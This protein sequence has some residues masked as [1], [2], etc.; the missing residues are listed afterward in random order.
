[1]DNTTQEPNDTTAQTT[2]GKLKY[3]DLCYNPEGDLCVQPQTLG[4]AEPS[5]STQLLPLPR[6]AASLM[7]GTISMAE[8]FWR[9]HERCLAVCLLLSPNLDRWLAGLPRQ[10]SGPQSVA[11]SLQPDDASLFPAGSHVAGS[12]QCVVDPT[13]DEVESILPQ[14]SGVHFVVG[15]GH[16]QT[17]RNLWAFVRVSGKLKPISPHD[18]TA[19]DTGITVEQ[20]QERITLV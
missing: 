6:I 1:M 5:R 11:W 7:T 12:W 4:E 14:F 13:D 17:P 3:I 10:Q 20:A 15:L 16:D 9:E 18:I 8:M 2:S 19:D